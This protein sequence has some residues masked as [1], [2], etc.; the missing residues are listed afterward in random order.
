MICK[1]RDALAA[2]LV[3]APT[4]AFED[5]VKEISRCSIGSDPIFPQKKIMNLIWKHQFL[6]L[7]VPFSQALDKVYGLAERYIPVV[8]PMNQQH[9]RLP[10]CDRRVGR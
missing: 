3:P 9:W 5:P 4:G 8:V 10:L 6:K 7:H 2:G 1:T